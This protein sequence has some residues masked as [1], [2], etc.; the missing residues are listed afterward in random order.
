[1]PV[2][3][4]QLTQKYNKDIIL[5]NISYEFI[6][7]QFYGIIGPNGSGKTTLLKTIARLLKA[8]EESIWIFGQDILNIREK[9]LAKSISMVPQI[10]NID[11]SFTVEDIVAMG[12]Y[13]YIQRLGQLS[14]E[15]KAIINNSLR[16]TKL[17]SYRDKSV[18]TLSGGELQRVILARALAQQTDIILLDEPLS[19][20]DIQH[21]IDILNLTKNLCT[22]ENKT[23]LCVMHDL[24]LAMKF[25]DQLLLINKGE[26]YASGNTKDVLSVEN[27]LDVYGINVE[28]VDIEENSIIIY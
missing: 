28:I 7:G 16:K 24:N 6:T 21:Q 19:H 15:D 25:C 4:E 27:I 10:F 12:R 17:L 2:C 1:M 5:N 11:S 20:L 9:T 14:E 23:I 22:Y 3:I 26:I 8:K 18:N 13:P